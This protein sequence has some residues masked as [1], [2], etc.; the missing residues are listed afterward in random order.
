[1]HHASTLAALLIVAHVV[2]FRQFGSVGPWNAEKRKKS[3]WF[4]PEQLF[5]DLLVFTGVLLLLIGLSAY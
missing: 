4:W 1:V 3:G 2:A 5:K